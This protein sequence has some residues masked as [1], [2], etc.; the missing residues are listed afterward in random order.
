MA[1]VFLAILPLSVCAAD[2]S[3]VQ[4]KAMQSADVVLLGE[5]HDNPLHH[6]GQAD[7]LRQVAP[8]A[9]V[10]EMLTPEMAATV[11]AYAGDLAELG[12]IIGWEAAGWPDFAIYQ[13]IFEALG[14][15]PAVGAAAPRETVR[16]AF[17]E[18]AAAVFG[19]Q[20]ERFGLSDPLPEDQLQT[21]VTA[22][23][24]AHC[25]AMPLEMMGGM[26]EAQRLRDAQFAKVTLNALAEYGASVVVIT[27]NGH[28]RR[29]WGVPF[30]IAQADPAVSTYSV[31]FI[32]APVSAPDARFDATIV[33]AP[34]QR[35]DPCAAF[36]N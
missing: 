2:L 19:P 34:A 21:R 9:V 10:F 26:V 12:A 33:T 22:Q 6:L 3:L 11:N 16:A 7:L 35:S 14:D 36:N 5:L 29:D 23:F 18:G 1:A 24:E 20:A 25:Q 4:T 30:A 13:P 17:A 27:G 31:G 28:A 15:A 8:K 32:E